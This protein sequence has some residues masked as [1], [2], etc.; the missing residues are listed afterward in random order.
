MIFSWPSSKFCI[1]VVGFRVTVW[2]RSSGSTLL[3][4]ALWKQWR[5]CTIRRIFSPYYITIENINDKTFLCRW[6]GRSSSLMEQLMGKSGLVQLSRSEFL[7][8]IKEKKMFGPWCLPN[9]PFKGPFTSSDCD[10]AATSLPNLIYC[11]GVVLLHWA[12][13]TVTATNF[14]VTGKS[15]CNPFRGA[16]LQRCRRRVAG[17]K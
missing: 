1:L 12:F 10:V 7:A 13:V 11:F 6:R 9:K 8:N 14:A 3:Y 2:S 5:V 15:L 4:W 16:T 17:C